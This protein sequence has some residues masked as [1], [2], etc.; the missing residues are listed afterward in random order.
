MHYYGMGGLLRVMRTDRD[1]SPS[2]CHCVLLVH[3][4]LKCVA[5][6]IVY[7]CSPGILPSSD[8]PV[9]KADIG[10]LPTVAATAVTPGF[11]HA[12]VY[13]LEERIAGLETALEASR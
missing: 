2:L 5:C 10:F 13:E 6:T 7:V 1:T 9:S 12:P 4:E 3:A 8:R 11:A